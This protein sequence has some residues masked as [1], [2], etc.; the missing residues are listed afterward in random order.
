M[1]M[2]MNSTQKLR[3]IVGAAL[4]AGLAACGNDDSPFDLGAAGSDGSIN[5][6]EASVLAGSRTEVGEP[7][8]VSNL[9][10]ATSETDEPFDL[11]D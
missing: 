4:L 10:L 9:A 1:G 5:Q 6:I 2:S 11:P 8:N 3:L 7:D